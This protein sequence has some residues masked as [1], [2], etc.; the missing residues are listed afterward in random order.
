[1]A[2]VTCNGKAVRAVNAEIKQLIA[3]GAS[4]IRVS[5]PLARHNLGVAVLQPVRITFEGSVGYYCG[6]MIDGPTLVIHGS[7]GWGLAESMMSGHVVVEGSAGNGAAASIRG[8]TVVIHGDTAARTAISMKGGLV[9]VGGNCGYMAGF[10]AQKGTL[11][12]CGDTADAFAD[13]MYE[14]VC[15]VGGQIAGLGNDAVVETPSE[16]EFAF[17]KSTLSEHLPESGRSQR[18]VR[19]FKKVVAGR[20]LWNFDKHDWAV[21]KDA[22]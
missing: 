11:I 20:R 17:L 8:G 4:E 13:S 12:V 6:G 14:T 16:K 21:W 19:Q 1:M 15:Y 7:A 10:I 9:V 3:K 5:N 18:D 2:D 22:L